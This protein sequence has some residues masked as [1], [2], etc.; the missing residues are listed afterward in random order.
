MPSSWDRKFMALAQHIA[1]WSKDR[2]RKVGAVI[3]GP[4]NEIRS[5]GFNGIP[6]G[7]DD[8]PEHRHDRASKEKYIWCG[9]AERNAIYNAAR[10]GV[11]LKG[12]RIYN[13]LFPCPSCTIAI[14]QCGL[15]TMVIMQPD[16]SDPQYGEDFKRAQTMLHEAQIQVHFLDK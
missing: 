6:R 5:T 12:C 13:T 15:D 11:A 7:V 1:T 9:C 4:D 3:V 16:L 10:I 8:T 14:I 2:G